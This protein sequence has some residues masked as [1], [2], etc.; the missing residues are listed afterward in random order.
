MCGFILTDLLA[1]SVLLIFRMLRTPS[2]RIVSRYSPMAKFRRSENEANLPVST[3]CNAH[4]RA[5][6]LM[7]TVT[8]SAMIME[9]L[10][11]ICS[12]RHYQSSLTHKVRLQT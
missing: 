1:R 10:G 2:L 9:L 12:L 7:W 8:G 4:S 6:F 5:S 3:I 11:P